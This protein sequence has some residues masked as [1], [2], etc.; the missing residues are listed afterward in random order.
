M[1]E[2]NRLICN[3]CLGPIELGRS[4]TWVLGKP[5][6]NHCANHTDLIT[7]AEADAMVA[8]ERER[9]AQ[10]ANDQAQIFRDEAH[11]QRQLG[12]R[13]MHK[14]AKMIASFFD[15]HASAIRAG[16]EKP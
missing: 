14:R 2:A 10:L 15:A 12:H 9:C 5:Y 1:S 16:K 6:H 4:F 3:G 8:A 7:R 13:E 11:D